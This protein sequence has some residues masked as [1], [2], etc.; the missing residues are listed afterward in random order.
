MREDDHIARGSNTRLKTLATVVGEMPERDRY[1][2]WSVPSRSAATLHSELL[3]DVVSRHRPGSCSW[4]LPYFRMWW[5]LV[6][7]NPSPFDRVFFCRI[8]LTS[9][10]PSCGISNSITQM[11]LAR[12]NLLSPS[13]PCFSARTMLSCPISPMGQ[14]SAFSES[15]L[16]WFKG[17]C[18]RRA[19]CGPKQAAPVATAG[20]WG[21]FPGCGVTWW[22]GRSGLWV[23]PP[24]MSL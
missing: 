11:T 23:G 17:S 12:K 2:S 20:S 3:V 13:D 14:D 1:R 16:P 21:S 9:G 7:V 5:C 19:V 8:I 4:M 10:S 18:M 24:R 22:V 15:Y 6:S